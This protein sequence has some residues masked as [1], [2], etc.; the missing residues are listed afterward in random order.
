MVLTLDP[1]LETA[2]A[3]SARQ[4][5]LTPEELATRVL[6]EQL[7]SRAAPVVPRDEWERRLLAASSDCGVSLPDSALTS[8][9]LYD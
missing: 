4:Q 5:G 3:Q 7:L 9:A 2:L 8:E 6:R 1:D